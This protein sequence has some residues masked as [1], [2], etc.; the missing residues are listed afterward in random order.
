MTNNWRVVVA[1]HVEM[2]GCGAF[3]IR[4]MGCVNKSGLDNK[5]DR[6]LFKV[7]YFYFANAMCALRLE[8]DDSGLA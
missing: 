5:C 1:R 4:I 8:Q 2:I 7:G 6:V 3:R